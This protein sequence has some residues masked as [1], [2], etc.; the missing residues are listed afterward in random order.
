MVYRPEEFSCLNFTSGVKSELK[1]S[2]SLNVTDPALLLYDAGYLTIQGFSGG[3]YTLGFP[4]KEMEEAF[5]KDIADAVKQSEKGTGVEIEKVRVA[6]MKPIPNFKA[7]MSAINS[8]IQKFVMRGPF[9]EWYD[10]QTMLFMNYA[11]IKAERQCDIRIVPSSSNDYKGTKKVD[12]TGYDEYTFFLFEI[13]FERDGCS[14]A[15]NDAK[16]S[17]QAHLDRNKKEEKPLNILAAGITFTA[18]RTKKPVTAYKAKLF[19]PNGMV[20]K[21]YFSSTR[22]KSDPKSDESFVAEKTST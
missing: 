2:R 16:Q 19:A 14:E 3:Y 18:D 15:W 12:V 20:L 5:Y 4:N 13:K 10:W 7:F 9:E 21:T 22:I 17:I 8:G 6:L 11:G 1:G